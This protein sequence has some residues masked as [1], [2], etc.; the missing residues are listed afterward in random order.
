MSVRI[1]L[2]NADVLDALSLD[3]F[4]GLREQAAVRFELGQCRAPLLLLALGLG[5]A[6]AL[7]L[8]EIDEFLRDGPFPRRDV[9]AGGCRRRPLPS[10]CL[11]RVQAFQDP[12]T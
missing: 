6:P 10:Q 5:A 9:F 7:G 8:L 3:A 4:P 1:E 2:G 11:E 12:F